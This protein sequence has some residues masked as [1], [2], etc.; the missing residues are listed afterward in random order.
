MVMAVDGDKSRRKRQV[1]VRYRGSS[2]RQ[3]KEHE[4][5]RY[6]GFWATPNGDFKQTK[7]LVFQR[8]EEAMEMIQHHPYTPEL[9]T[10]MFISKGVGSFRYSA[11]VVPWTESELMKLQDKWIQGFRVAWHLKEFTAKPP[12]VLPAECGGLELI[13]PKVILAQTL[14]SHIQRC[15]LHKDVVQK[16]MLREL[17][18]AK[19]FSLCTSF[20]DIREEMELWTWQEAQGNVWLRTAKCLRELQME[21]DLPPGIE[22]EETGGLGW[23]K[24][25]RTLRTAYRRAR[26]IGGEMSARRRKGPGARWCKDVWQGT[27]GKTDQWSMELGEWQALEEGSR[28]LWQAGRKLWRAGKCTVATVEQQQLKKGPRIPA[29]LRATQET[30]GEQRVRIVIPRGMAGIPERERLQ[31]QKLLDLVDWKGLGAMVGMKPNQRGVDLR[32]EKCECCDGVSG[33]PSIA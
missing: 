16:A 3:L 17:E 7:K 23:A 2:V 15:L 12:F 9:A 30:D 13:T 29:G 25:T 26:S 21:L 28:A 32:V 33:Q 24:A 5:C 14:T 10:Q 4:T 22:E 1:E 20:Q 8:T 6:L 31:L 27:D 19:A 18:E 11:A